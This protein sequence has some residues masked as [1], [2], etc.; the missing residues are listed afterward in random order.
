M[1]SHLR[2]RYRGQTHETGADGFAFG[3]VRSN[4]H[5]V[6]LWASKVTTSICTVSVESGNKSWSSLPI[7]KIMSEIISKLSFPTPSFSLFISQK[8][9]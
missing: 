5:T 4:K 3:P 6:A 9:S 8:S 7:S 2:P 1:A